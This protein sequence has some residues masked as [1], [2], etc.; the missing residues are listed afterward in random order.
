MIPRLARALATAPVARQLVAGAALLAVVL[1]LLAAFTDVGLVR[2]LL[3]AA[4]GAAAAAV[5]ARAARRTPDP[6]GTDSTGTDPAGADPAGADPA[7]ADPAG[8]DPAGADPAGADPAGADPA[9]ADPAGATDA[10]PVAA[11]RPGPAA[12]PVSGG[13]V[14]LGPAGVVTLARGVLVVAVA[15][16]IGLDGP[17]QVALVALALVAFGLDAVD[18]IVARRTGTASELGARF[19]METDA[20]LLLVLSV[21]VAIAS[22]LWWAPALGLLRYAF[23]GAARVLPWLQGSLP[24]RRSAK[25]VAALQGVVLIAAAAGLLPGTIGH[26]V[27]AV[28][29]AAL[30]WSFGTSVVWLWRAADEHP[31]RWRAA[32]AALLTTVCA[33]LVA[34]ILVLPGDPVNIVPAAFLRLPIEIVLG[35]A[36]LALLPG[37]ARRITGA[38]AGLLLAVVGLLKLFDLGFVIFLDRPFDPVADW[39]LIG[40]AQEFLRG[41]LGPAGAVLVAVLAGVLAVGLLVATAL[42]VVRLAGLAAR[43][44][45]VALPGAAALGTVW[46][47]VWAVVGAQLVP[48]VP[49]AA[50]DGVTQLRDRA[51]GIPAAIADQRSF[52]S[53]LAEDAY[54]DVPG[55][56]LLGALRGKDVVF[57]VVESYGRTALEDP[58]MAPR[59]T[60]LLDDSD[61][62]LDDA[63]FDSRSGFLTSPISGGGSWLAHATLFSGLRIDDQRRHDALVTSDR[64]TLVRAF[65]DAGWETT[66]VMPGTT[67]AW[68]EADFYGHQRVHAFD[69]L[70]Y[71][72]PPFSW[73]PMPDQYA[74]SAFSRLEHDRTDRGPLMAEIALTSSH[75]PWTPVPPMLG[76]DEVGDGSVYAPYADDQRTFESIFAGDPD[77]IRE[78]YLRSTEYAL[79]ATLG[80]IERF[81]DDDLVVVM[82][83]DHQPASVVTG[84]AASRD[85]PVSIITRDPE[86]L[87]RID[88]WDWSAG[89]R[90]PPA[91]PVWPM[92]AFRDRFL[93]AYGQPIPAGR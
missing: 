8:A 67:R 84:A 53:E 51:V 41:T 28:A 72:G 64:L 80:W 66:A 78:D 35:V 76:W 82:L 61:R 68:P 11:P 88:D 22:H 7:G 93:D 14:T 34:L 30:L 52:A 4:L 74:L 37:R 39:V 32:G 77:A 21:H 20:L 29:L 5:L 50:A 23:V 9:G 44:R 27:L 71:Q 49:V 6:A 85:V 60:A 10:D 18:G 31:V 16:L 47:V 56:Q 92:D 45:R 15:T 24:V 55:D 70:D 40:N 62:R 90:P 87:D 69:G 19:D 36:V 38:V 42:A 43:H 63:G 81:G 25:V 73:S 26:A 57:A 12:A 17:G 54:A 2:A 75:A 91:A 13:A 59:T 89:L 58:E 33:A 48:G 46:L 86:V 83:G 65:R 1:T 79:E 3:G